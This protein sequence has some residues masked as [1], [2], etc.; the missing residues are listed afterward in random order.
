MRAAHGLSTLTAR[1]VATAF[2]LS[3]FSSACDLG[4]AYTP[5]RPAGCQC[6]G[7]CVFSPGQLGR[8]PSDLLNGFISA[9]CLGAEIYPGWVWAWVDVPKC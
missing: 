5:Q 1:H 2:D 3:R 7:P 6:Q 4:G 8:P 9:N